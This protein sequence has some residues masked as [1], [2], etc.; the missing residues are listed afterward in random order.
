VLRPALLT[1]YKYA[2][3]DR[4]L[5]VVVL[6]DGLTEQRER[7][8]LLQTIGQR[9]AGCRVFCIGVGNDVNRPLLEQI[10]D[11]AGGLAAFLSHGD[12]YT[13]A[14]QAFR[15]KL[16]RPVAAN[17]ALT[18]DGVTPYDLEPAILPNLFHGAPIRIY[19]RYR[20]EGPAK[21]RLT[22][23]VR[24]KPF[25]SADT[26]VFPER[27][28]ANPEI[29]RMWAWKRID[30]LQKKADRTGSRD[31]VINE[32]VR[33]G[34]TYSIVSE[35]TSFLVL[36]NDAEYQRW[37]IERRNVRR[38]GRDRIAQASREESLRLLR[39]RALSD[40]GPAAA[41]KPATVPPEQLASA[42]PTQ[43]RPG[44]PAANPATAPTQPRNQGRSID[45]DIGTGP[46]GPLFVAIAAWMARRRRHLTA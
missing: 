11:D 20:G 1:A 40:I 15:R 35:Y 39:E 13:Q 46:V 27:D 41:G 16:M 43:P 21:V 45:L 4:I 37:Q 12:N 38:L 23:D 2:D 5:N 32:I 34:E 42:A 8:E 26:M 17:L 22:G 29:E 33:L 24:G 19:G 25:T 7:T 30:Q 6:S 9:P 3:P 36:E 14:A 28:D 10:A 18:I 31:A 44:T